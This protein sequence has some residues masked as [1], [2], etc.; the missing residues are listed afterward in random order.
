MSDDSP[1]VPVNCPVCE[2]TTRVPV[3]EVADAVSKHNEHRHDGD[4]VAGVDPAIVDRI[5]DLAAEELGLTG[6]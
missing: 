4:E 5:A 6:E 1:T 3:A 2:T